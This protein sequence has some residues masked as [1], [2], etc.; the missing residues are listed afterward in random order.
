[1]PRIF[2]INIRKI[3]VFFM[4]IFFFSELIQI[5]RLRNSLFLIN[6]ISV[7]LNIRS[8]FNY[9]IAES[10]VLRDNYDVDFFFKTIFF[11]KS[12]LRKIFIKIFTE[13]RIFFI[14][15]MRVFFI[16]GVRVSFMRKF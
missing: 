7:L 8:L 1:M 15:K 2:L 11:F 12:R 13:M 6:V 14:K 9:L 3:S 4:T 10:F 5:M 16:K